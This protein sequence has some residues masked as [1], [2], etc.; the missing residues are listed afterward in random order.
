[1]A[2]A[3]SII[4]TPDSLRQ[5][6][7]RVRGYRADHDS[8]ISQLT[9]LINSLEGEWKGDAQQALYDEFHAMEPTFR[10]F[11]ELLGRFAE[12]MDID[13]NELEAKDQELATRTHNSFQ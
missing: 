11:S 9:N 3:G 10:A 8:V 13:A 6:A 2:G 1:M 5:H 12:T 7:S 4:I